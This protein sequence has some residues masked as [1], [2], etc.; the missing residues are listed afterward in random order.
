MLGG[1]ASAFGGDKVAGL[2][3]LATGFSKLNLD[4]SMIGKFAPAILSFV[5][6]KAGPEVATL[7]SKVV[8]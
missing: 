6:A 3:S 4:P 8:K 1:L 2:A 7:L 5:Q